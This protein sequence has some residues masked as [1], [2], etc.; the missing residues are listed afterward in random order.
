MPFEDGLNAFL[1]EKEL[2]VTGLLQSLELLTTAMADNRP[3]SDCTV[4]AAEISVAK[5]REA[6]SGATPNH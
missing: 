6:W 3:L 4:F 2:P 5:L 1:L